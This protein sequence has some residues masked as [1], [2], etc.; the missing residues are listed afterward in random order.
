MYYFVNSYQIFY[1]GLVYF[2]DSAINFYNY[3]TE[4]M[5]T[6]MISIAIAAMDGSK[7]TRLAEKP[8]TAGEMDPDKIMEDDIYECK[9]D[10]EYGTNL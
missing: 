4:I 8:V 9:W 7:R 3:S 1:A 10:Y 5:I 6:D 2:V